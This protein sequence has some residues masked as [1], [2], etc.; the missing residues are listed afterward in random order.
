MKLLIR[1]SQADPVPIGAKVGRGK[2]T[3]NLLGVQLA[4]IFVSAIATYQLGILAML[5]LMAIFSTV[6]TTPGLRRWMASRGIGICA[7]R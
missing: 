7:R 3:H 6:I 4:G 2:L 1:I 5:M